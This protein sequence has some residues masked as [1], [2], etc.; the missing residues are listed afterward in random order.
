M[1]STSRVAQQWVSPPSHQTPLGLRSGEGVSVGET[2]KGFTPTTG[3]R[4]P[5]YVGIQKIR[6]TMPGR[7]GDFDANCQGCQG[8]ILLMQ[9][10]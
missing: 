5:G 3:A 7:G 8:C 9:W 1:P 6:Q 10:A 2:R 4:V